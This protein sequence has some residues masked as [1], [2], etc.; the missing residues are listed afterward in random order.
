MSSSVGLP[1]SR[2]HQIS[3][4]VRCKNPTYIQVLTLAGSTSITKTSQA[5]TLDT[6][7]DGAWSVQINFRA[8]S[9]TFSLPSRG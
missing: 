8:Y 7:V 4:M 2:I 6:I 5:L 1:M 3:E 9:H